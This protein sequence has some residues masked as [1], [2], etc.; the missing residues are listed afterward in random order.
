MQETEKK[1]WIYN[2]DPQKNKMLHPWNKKIFFEKESE[3]KN[4]YLEIKK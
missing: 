2:L 3:N 1:N 4:E